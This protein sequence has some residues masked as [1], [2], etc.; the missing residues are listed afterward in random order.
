M[1]SEKLDEFQKKNY[2]DVKSDG[3]FLEIYSQ[4]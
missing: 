1:S 3:I 4:D 2:D